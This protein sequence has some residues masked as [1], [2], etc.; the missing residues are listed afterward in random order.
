MDQLEQ[1]VLDALHA[2][3]KVE[4]IKQLRHHRNI[5]LREAKDIIDNYTAQHP[6]LLPPTQGAISKIIGLIIVG[7]AVLIIVSKFGL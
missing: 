6:E 4:A 3:R 1:E 2:G 7:I 5:G